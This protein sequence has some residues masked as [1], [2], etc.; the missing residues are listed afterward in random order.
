MTKAL[1]RKVID[2]YTKALF[3]GFASQAE[4]ITRLTHKPTKGQ[5]REV[6]MQG[7]LKHFGSSW[8]SGKIAIFFTFL[9]KLSPNSYK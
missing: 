7:L 8:I 3:A 1:G 4:S 9:W 2:P 6:F 5:I